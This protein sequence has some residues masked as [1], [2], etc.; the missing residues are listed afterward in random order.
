MRVLVVFCHP[1]PGSFNAAL[2]QRVLAAL[3]ERGHEVDDC[4][5]YAEGFDPVLRAEHWAGYHEVPSNREPVRGYVERLL[6]AQALVLVFPVWNFGLPA[7]LK[8]FFDRVLLP[9][10]SFDMSDPRRLRPALT[11]LRHVVGVATY[12]APRWRLWWLGDGP[13]AL[14]KRVMRRLT[15]GRARVDYLPCYHLNVVGP[16]VRAAFLQRVGVAMGRIA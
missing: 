10:V 12:G 13:R 3:R 1:S 5:L 7:M 14:V 15:D 11:H 8:G 2:H 6:Q 4:D 9:G 16:E